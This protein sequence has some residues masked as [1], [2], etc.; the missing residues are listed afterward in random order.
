MNKL[1]ALACLLASTSVA[2]ADD[3]P[4]PPAP[5]TTPAPEAAPAPEPGRPRSQ[6]R[7]H[8]VK[9]SDRLSVACLRPLAKVAL[10]LSV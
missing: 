6:G 8:V 3:P 1:I 10:A 5:E 2:F 4:P 9:E 7:A